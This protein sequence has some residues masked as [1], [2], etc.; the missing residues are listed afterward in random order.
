[1]D[2]TYSEDSEF[3]LKCTGNANQRGW[4]KSGSNGA[5]CHFTAR[6]QVMAGNVIWDSISQL[7]FFAMEDSS[8]NGAILQDETHA[9]NG[10]NGYCN[11]YLDAGSTWT[12]TGDSRVSN[13]FC[14]GTIWDT[15]GN[16]VSIVDAD[17]T[18]Y[19]EG[20]SQYTITVD[21]YSNTADFSGASILDSWYDYSVEKI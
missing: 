7:D 8:L 6:N 2:I 9:G 14:E 16:S 15:D 3:F 13:L 4:G 19:V 10:G 20:N 12:V 18:V 11:V 5:D 21:S 1:M 17:G